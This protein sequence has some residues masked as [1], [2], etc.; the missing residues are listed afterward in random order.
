MDPVL[1][2]LTG[3]DEEARTPATARC[4]LVRRQVPRLL[5]GSAKERD[6]CTSAD[7]TATDSMSACHRPLEKGRSASGRV[8][9]TGSCRSP[10]FVAAG[11]KP[12]GSLTRR[13]DVEHGG[14]V[15]LDRRF[16]LWPGAPMPGRF[17]FH[18]PRALPDGRG[19]GRSTTSRNRC[20][21]AGSIHHFPKRF[22]PRRSPRLSARTSVFGWQCAIGD[23]SRTP[24]AASRFM[25]TSVG[26]IECSGAEVTTS[27]PARWT[28]A[29]FLQRL[30]EPKIA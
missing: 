15:T 3:R 19:D 1:A 16:R 6:V 2:P 21:S 11:R 30:A 9:A 7:A 4:R 29:D 8:R 24:I 20:S 26:M 5:P 14:R 17:L 22:V 28:D 10:F 23:A 27:C 25:L 12:A 18:R 13:R